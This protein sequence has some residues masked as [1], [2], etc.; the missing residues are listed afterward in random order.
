MSSVIADVPR[1]TRSDVSARSL[2]FDVLVLAH[3]DAGVGKLLNPNNTAG[4]SEPSIVLLQ[5]ATLPEGSL[6][7]YR[8]TV[9]RRA[10]VVGYVDLSSA[11]VSSR[12]GCSEALFQWIGASRYIFVA[13]SAQ[14]IASCY[15]AE[16]CADILEASTHPTSAKLDVRFWRTSAFTSTDPVLKC[17]AHLQ[18][19]IIENTKF[20]TLLR[21]LSLCDAFSYE[22]RE[23][24]AAHVLQVNFDVL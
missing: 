1:P 16:W 13:Y 3:A 5:Q 11:M 24:G 19:P 2:A 15:A 21:S 22:R 18:A 6:C 10:W 17:A 23:A 4:T 12:R 7:V 20:L 14:A 9:D 8:F